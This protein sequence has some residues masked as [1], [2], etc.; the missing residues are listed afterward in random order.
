MKT[1]NRRTVLAGGIPSKGFT[2]V[3]LLVVIAIIGILVALLLPAVQAAREAAR[4]TECKNHL[5]QIGLAFLNH[6]SVHKHLPTGGWSWAWDGDPDR[7]AGEKQTGSWPYNILPFIEEQELYDLGS[8]GQP[9]VITAQQKEQSAIRQT[10]PVVAFYCPSRRSAQAYPGYWRLESPASGPKN[11]NYSRDIAKTDYA[12]CAGKSRVEFEVGTLT[13]PWPSPEDTAEEDN[14]EPPSGVS[15]QRSVIRL[16]EI[17][18]GTSNTYMV[19]EKF[20]DPDFY[21]SINNFAHQNDHHGVYCYGFD[22]HRVASTYWVPWQDQQLLVKQ[23]YMNR[24]YASKAKMRFGSAHPAVW[25][26]TF[27]D[28]SVHGLSYD[29]DGSTHQWLGDRFDGQVVEAHGGR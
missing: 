26:M 3:E 8:D 1:R 16:T 10:T 20:M 13:V 11:S 18:D 21:H 24:A 2:L 9:D 12:A 28:G 14:I 7:G 4:R 29:I 15:F 25:H 17:T 19:G 5:K 23:H 27:C 6:E 22:Q